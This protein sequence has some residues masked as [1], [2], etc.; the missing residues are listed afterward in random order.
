MLSR[1]QNSFSACSPSRPNFSSTLI[2]QQRLRLTSTKLRNETHRPLYQS[3]VYKAFM[4]C[5]LALVFHF[6]EES[7]KRLIQGGASGSVLRETRI[8]D[9]MGRSIVIFCTFISLFAF[10]ELRR[11][12]GEDKF[13]A[14]VFRSRVAGDQGPS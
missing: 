2:A 7:I 8:D 13:N 6:I 10:R 11:A 9:L 14:L 3:A 4:F 5:L 1:K 12:M